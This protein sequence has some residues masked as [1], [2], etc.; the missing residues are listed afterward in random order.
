NI[1]M[2]T[3]SAQEQ[4]LKAD[5][6]ANP[7]T[8]TLA[9][10]HHP[11]FSS[12]TIAVDTMAR[13]AWRDLYAAGAEL[14]IVGHHHDYERFAPQTPDGTLDQTFGIR[15]IVAGTGGGEGLFAFGTTAANSLVRNNSTF[16]VLKL[17][18]QTGGYSWRFIPV[19]GATFSDTGSST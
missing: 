15:E 2:G 13:A 5:L 19:A 10:W 17:T 7:R 18:L 4:W 16:G 12:S 6:A 9:Y 14:V 1:A 11:L 3:G 8:C